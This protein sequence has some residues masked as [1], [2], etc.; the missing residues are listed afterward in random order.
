MTNKVRDD[1]D[2]KC[3]VI[4]KMLRADATADGHIKNQVIHRRTFGPIFHTQ[5]RCTCLETTE[6]LMMS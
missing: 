3:D 1:T 5:T 6:M 2:E 4:Q